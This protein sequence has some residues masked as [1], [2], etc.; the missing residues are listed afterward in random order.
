MAIC[1]PSA[2]LDISTI[3]QYTI[4]CNLA[5]VHCTSVVKFIR[6][7]KF[8]LVYL[9][10]HHSVLF[11][12]FFLSL[13]AAFLLSTLHH[14]DMIISPSLCNFTCRDDVDICTFDDLLPF[15]LFYMIVTYSPFS[16]YWPVLCNYSFYKLYIYLYNRRV[17]RHFAKVSWIYS[18]Y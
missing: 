8:S 11:F 13:V 14:S 9:C 5:V 4:D 12:S 6:L 1:R 2:R 7:W 15:W 17:P 16:L 18:F 3:Y 10:V